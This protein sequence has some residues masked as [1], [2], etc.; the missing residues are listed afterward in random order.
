MYPLVPLVA[1]LALR[2]AGDA[3]EGLDRREGVVTL[4]ACFA[5]GLSYAYYA[6][7]GCVLLWRPAFLAGSV[8]ASSGFLA[9]PR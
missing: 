9:W 2:A 7:F 8:P 4:S 1:L 5:Q 3:P 6:F